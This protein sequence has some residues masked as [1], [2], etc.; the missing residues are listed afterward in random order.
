[1]RGTMAL[2]MYCPASAC[3]TDFRY[4]WLLLLSTWVGIRGGHRGQKGAWPFFEPPLARPYHVGLLLGPG[5]GQRGVAGPHAGQRHI[6]A[7]VGDGGFGGHHDARGDWGETEGE[8]RVGDIQ[9]GQRGLLHSQCTSTS[10]LTL[11]LPM[12]LC[13]SQETGSVKKV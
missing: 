3:V 8:G 11:V 12:S 10:V 9:G 7:D 6:G 4:S 5:E 13:T 1:M 2:Q